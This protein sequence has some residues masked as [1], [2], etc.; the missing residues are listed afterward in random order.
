MQLT[1]IIGGKNLNDKLAIALPINHNLSY[2][3]VI[4]IFSMSKALRSVYYWYDNSKTSQLL[5]YQYGI[6]SSAGEALNVGE[7]NL[8]NKY[9]DNNG[10]NNLDYTI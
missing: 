6:N 9:G 4:P 5:L 1:I 10:I 7:I 8:K 3:S 2:F